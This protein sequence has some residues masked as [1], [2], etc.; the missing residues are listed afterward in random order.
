MKTLIIIALTLA[1]IGCLAQGSSPEPVKIYVYRAKQ[2]TAKYRALPFYC[3]ERIE[4]D[5]NNGRYFILTLSPGLHTFRGS[6]KGT[7]LQ[8]E[9]KSGEKYFIRAEH[10]LG[11]FKGTQQITSVDASLAHSEMY[12]LKPVAKEKIWDYERVSQQ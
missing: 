8:L 2:F 7:S 1:S 12:D 3:D 9:L 11:A 6:D 5:L 10:A 4:A